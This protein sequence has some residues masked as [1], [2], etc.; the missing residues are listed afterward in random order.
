MRTIGFL[1]QYTLMAGERWHFSLDGALKLVERIIDPTGHEIAYRGKRLDSQFEKVEDLWRSY[2]CALGLTEAK[3]RREIS[4]EMV[5]GQV[6]WSWAKSN[7][8]WTLVKEEIPCRAGDDQLPVA[9]TV[10]TTVQRVTGSFAT[11]Y[12][13]DDPERLNHDHLTQ[14]D[15]LISASDVVTELIAYLNILIE[16]KQAE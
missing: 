16:L 13:R 4:Q 1:I 6:R 15:I 7:H 2:V 12:K 11:D 8:Q 5:N 10:V 3:A 9:E 14:I